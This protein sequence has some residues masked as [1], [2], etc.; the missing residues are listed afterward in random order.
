MATVRDDVAGRHRGVDADPLAA[1]AVLGWAFPE[2][3]AVEICSGIAP[4]ATDVTMKA[5]VRSMR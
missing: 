2:G 4:E 3:D 1:S 5:L